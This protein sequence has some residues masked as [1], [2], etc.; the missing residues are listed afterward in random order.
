MNHM[1]MHTALPLAE[2]GDRK[3]LLDA[4][5]SKLRGGPDL[6][7]MVLFLT[8]VVLLIGVI[9]IAARRFGIEGGGR[10]ECPRDLLADA[11]GVLS[12][13]TGE[14][15][16]LRYVSER[17]RMREP[18]AMLLSPR[19]FAIAVTTVLR[20]SPDPERHTRLAALCRKLFDSRM[21]D[22]T[23]HAGD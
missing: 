22:V 13:N 20:A 10:A 11:F 5:G 19:L 21:P 12:L 3:A 16:D 18:L 6:L 7:S 2:V 8:G 17:S 14:Q 1:W 4:M 9:Y 23:E 15:S